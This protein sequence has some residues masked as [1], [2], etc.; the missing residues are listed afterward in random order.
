MAVSKNKHV[1]VRLRFVSAILILSALILV[2]KLYFVQMVYGE[3][4]SERADRQYVRTNSDTFNRG[5]IFFEEK[6]GNYIS[7]ATLK[8]G[9]TLA[10]NPETLE[11]PHDIFKKL[12]SVTELDE[13]IFFLKAGKEGDPYEEL[14]Q[15]LT[16]EDADK[17]EAFDLDGVGL[18]KTKWRFYP[19]RDLA[20]HTLGFVGYKGDEL[21]GRYGV[22][23]YYDDVLSR[24]DAKLYVNFFAE[25]FSQIGERIVHRNTTR[26]GDVY[27][28]IEP[29]VQLQLEGVLEEIQNT[30][31]SRIVAGIII[32]P[33]T[34]EI[35][36]LGS[37]PSYDPNNYSEVD[38]ISVFNNPLVQNVYEM[39]SII[40]PIT[41]AAGIDAGV[42]TPET[43]YDDKGRVTTNGYTISNYDGGARGVVSMQEVLNQSLNTGVSFVTEKLGNEK[44]T[45]YFKAFGL[46]TETGIDLPNEAYNLTENLDSPRDIEHFTASFGQGI[47]LTPISTVRALSALGNGGQLITPHVVKRVEY[48]VG[49]NKLID[50]EEKPGVISPETSETITRMLVKVVDEALRDGNVALEHYSVA[51]KT[52]TAQ[53]S[54]PDGGYYEDRYLH[55]FFGYFPAY[56]PQFLVFLLNIEPQ[57]ARY[58]SET[59]TDPFIDLTKFLIS[60][61]G[62]TPDR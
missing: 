6:N 36:G 2:S 18:Y 3:E 5:S 22:E 32:N 52:G 34:G 56:E 11:N 57:G 4:F 55:S 50:P 61:Y 59:L 51:A 37:L 46:R 49:W 28:T 1:T 62:V 35:Y 41:M 48:T 12:S 24:E 8:N 15:K 17:I 10:I 29:T 21:V 23:E 13:D 58:A 40:K 9:Y 31:G 14:A 60:Y 16:K 26:E 25:V 47:A 19:G 7:A 39:G 33:Q 42:V 43:T 38:D 30:W 20:S 44:F 54:S 53:I 27:L 45:E